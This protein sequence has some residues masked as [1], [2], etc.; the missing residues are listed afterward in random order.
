[1]KPQKRTERSHVLVR[2]SEKMFK[3]IWPTAFTRNL[4]VGVLAAALAACGGGGGGGTTSSSSSTSTAGPTTGTG[5]TTGTTATVDNSWLTFSQP[6]LALVT[7]S[8]SAQ[9]ISIVATSSKLIAE[10]VNLAI[11][12]NGGIISPSSLAI[13]KL[14]A[15]SY[16][17]TFSLLQTLT[18]RTYQSSLTIKMCLD[19]PSTC[20]QPYPG[21]PWTIP[22]TVTVAPNVWGAQAA[23]PLDFSY[24]AGSSDTHK[25]ALL[26][27]GTGKGWS[28][29]SKPD[30]L[31]LSALSG[32][33]P[34]SVTATVKPGIGQ[35]KNVGSLVIAATTG[36][37]VSIPASLNVTSV[38]VSTG[39]GNPLAFNM[40]NG[41]RATQSVTVKVGTGNTMRWTATSNAPWLILSQLTFTSPVTLDATVDPSVGVLAANQYTTTIGFQASDG[42][43]VVQP[44]TLD[45]KQPTISSNL[46]ALVVGGE[47]G[48]TLTASA[49]TFSLNTGAFTHPWKVESVP[50][51]LTPVPSGSL[52]TQASP[53]VR[54]TPVV[55]QVI[56]SGVKSGEIVVSAQVNG[57]KVT[58]TIPAVTKLEQRKLLFSETGMLFVSTPE[59]STLSRTITVRDNFGL[60]TGWTASSDATWLKLTPSGVT[61]SSGLSDFALSVDT[62]KL[63]TMIG[64]QT[65]LATVTLAPSDTTVQAPEKLVVGLWYGYTSPSTVV[66]ASVKM[67]TQYQYVIADPVRPLVYAHTYFGSDIDVFN[68]YT[69]K[70]IGTH[71][72]VATRGATMAI[73]HDGSSLYV[74]DIGPSVPVA[75]APPATI[76]MVTLDKPSANMVRRDVIK[77]QTQVSPLEGFGYIRPNGVG[78]LLLGRNTA[79]STANHATIAASLPAQGGTLEEPV[80]PIAVSRD[81]SKTVFAGNLLLGGVVATSPSLYVLDSG[82]NKLMSELKWPAGVSRVGANMWQ[83]AVFSADG[84]RFYTPPVTTASQVDQMFLPVWDGVTGALKGTISSIYALG[85]SVHSTPDGTLY[86]V[87]GGGIALPS[88][89]IARI[90]NGGSAANKWYGFAPDAKYLMS[91]VLSADGHI[92]FTSFSDGIVRFKVLD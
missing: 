36:E 34:T 53:T 29:V 25:V 69:G 4:V 39:G 52:G 49:L 46:D 65:Y 33:A 21:S 26:V 41:T 88:L 80:G 55:S 38:A 60:S 82:F 3:T 48:R 15:T 63:P 57:D 42:T 54:L 7:Q 17:A 76:S 43:T 75:G 31:D 79:F 12:D 14:G 16:Q 62:T 10:P 90:P 73:T 64:D 24:A 68:V 91:F 70:L 37:R 44:V 66:P 86:V 6:E 18:A 74:L 84:S 8:G 61:N 77:L 83:S 56:G 32:T 11:Q 47:N 72:N 59:I 20:E 22:Y 85:N 13:T 92:A 9:S 45:L 87:H 1:M 23:A 51:W 30:W 89:A 19:A 27:S 81:G 50:A 35:G 67:P 2:W 40:I 71:K 78:M 58:K 5:S 28:V